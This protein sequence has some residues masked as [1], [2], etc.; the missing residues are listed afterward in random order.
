MVSYGYMGL[1]PLPPSLQY[2]KCIRRQLGKKRC[3]AT[4]S[5]GAIFWEE[6]LFFFQG[7]HVIEW[8]ERQACLL[9]ERQE[10]HKTLC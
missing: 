10:V 8:D 2:L 4:S 5:D 7:C 3:A 1:A 9:M 6:L